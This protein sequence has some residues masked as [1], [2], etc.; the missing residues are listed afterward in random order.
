MRA[1]CTGS[2]NG[3]VACCVAAAALFASGCNGSGGSSSETFES[4]SEYRSASGSLNVELT[5]SGQKNRIGELEFTSNVYNG[6]YAAPVLRASA[7]GIINLRLRNLSANQ[8]SN[9]HYHGMNVSPQGNSDNVFVQ[10]EPENCFDYTISI[11]SGQSPG[12]NWYHSH[13][14][15]LAETQVFNG[16]SGGLIVDGIVEKLP[17]LLGLK[18]RV[19][20]LKDVQ[21]SEDGTVNTPDYAKPTLRT[22]NGISKPTIAIEPGE[23]Q[24][25]R[26]GNMGANLFY[27]L[28]IDG[29]EMVE[30]VRDGNIRTRPNPQQRLILPPGARTEFLVTGGAPGSY[31]FRT[32]AVDTGPD[33][34]PTPEELLGTLIVS[35]SQQEPV[36]APDTLVPSKDLRTLPLTRSRRMVFSENNDA[37]QFFINGELYS[38]SRDDV[39]VPLGSVEKWELVNNSQELHTFHI[40]QTDFQVIAKNGRP[41]E[42]IGYQDTVDIETGGTTTIIIPFTSPTQV[43]R[44][45]YHCHILEHEDGGMM[46]NIVVF[47]PSDPGAVDNSRMMQGRQCS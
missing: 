15:G 24:F 45:V 2:R 10:V 14:M 4:P 41:E 28:S 46:Q 1:I 37:G 43:G 35:G 18:E 20:I 7:G 32:L 38:P 12:L 21:A 23:T 39:T 8:P 5:I 31:A 17:F 34:D 19:M 22:I 36:V 26:V 16:L 25:F 42:F 30:L 29:H 33:G 27:Q 40:H 9:V 47:D 6:D 44:F 11:P 3:L 13:M